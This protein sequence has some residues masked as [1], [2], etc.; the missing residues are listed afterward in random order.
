MALDR[1][2]VVPVARSERVPVRRC[3]NNRICELGTRPF[4]TDVYEAGRSA[5]RVGAVM[6]PRM[7]RGVRR[8]EQ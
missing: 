7:R 3:A 8:I 5:S 2:P 4:A 6:R 1:F